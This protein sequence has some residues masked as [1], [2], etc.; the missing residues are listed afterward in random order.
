MRPALSLLHIVPG[1]KRR[2]LLAWLSPDSARYFPVRALASP[3]APG[4]DPFPRLSPTP[5]TYLP[6]SDD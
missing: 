5:L 1:R 4:L 6:L 3:L 2:A